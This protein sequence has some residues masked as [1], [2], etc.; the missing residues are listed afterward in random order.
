MLDEYLDAVLTQPWAWGT[1]DCCTFAAGWIIARTAHDPLGAHRGYSTSAGA[2]RIIAM[3]GSLLG[4]VSHQM[5]ECGFARTDRPEHGDIG[6]V[7]LPEVSGAMNLCGA[8]VVI[9]HTTRWIGR[10]EEGLFGGDF[11][12][13]AA[14]RIA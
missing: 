14:W 4:L 5:A 2:R 3:H 11:E 13:V 6:L 10:A 9:M 12:P 8:S 7:E 1:M